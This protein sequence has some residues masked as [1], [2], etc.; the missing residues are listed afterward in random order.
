MDREPPQRARILHFSPLP[1]LPYG[2][3]AYVPRVCT[4]AHAP[5]RLTAVIQQLLPASVQVVPSGRQELS[6][7]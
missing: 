6:L 5:S 7:Q 4:H 1:Q 3:V 2:T